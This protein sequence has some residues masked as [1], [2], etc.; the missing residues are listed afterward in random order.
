M[1]YQIENELGY[2]CTKHICNSGAISR[3]PNAHFDMVRLG[4]GMYGLG[5]NQEEQNFLQN[6]GC[7]KTRISQIKKVKAGDTVSY[8]RSGKIDNQTTLATLPIG[9]ADGFN[10]LLGNGKFSVLINGVLCKTV[11]NIC[12]DMCMVD[13]TGV[14]CSEGDEVI[15]FE[16]V[17]QINDLAK[18]LQTIPYEVLTNV[19]G[20]VKRVYVQE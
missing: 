18:M 1:T 4:I 12:M 3:F 15:I 11:G 20:R 14:K 13:I 19:S 5:V 8:N 17:Q 7:L 2:S 16:S 10:R 9:Y 6:V